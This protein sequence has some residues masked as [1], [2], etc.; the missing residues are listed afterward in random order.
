[1]PLATSLP[2]RNGFS[3]GVANY[4]VAPG[5][6]DSRTAVEAQNPAT[7][8]QT[9]N[10][11]LSTVTAAGSIINLADGTYQSVGSNYAIQ[12]NGKVV[13][14]GSGNPI[15]VKATNPGGAVITGSALGGAFTLGAWIT[16]SS[17]Y[18]FQGLRFSVQG[19]GAGAVLV[20]G[21]SS[22][23]EFFRCTFV[24][25]GETAFKTR[26]APGAPCTDIWV[27]SCKFAPS[28]T[29]TWQRAGAQ[30]VGEPTSTEFCAGLDTGNSGGTTGYYGTKGTHCMYVGQLSGA[31]FSGQ[32][33][34]DRM[35]IANCV[36]IGNTPGRHIECGPMA[37]STYI[38]NNTFYGNEPG[39]YSNTDDVSYKAGYAG[40]G[41]EFWKNDGTGAWQTQNNRVVNN[42]FVDLQ[43]HA[44]YGSTPANMTGNEV[45]NNLAW[46]L[47][48]GYDGATEWQGTR[49]DDYLQT[50]LGFTL[51]TEP[52]G[53]VSSANPLLVS[54]SK[55][56]TADLSLQDASPARGAAD[57]AYCPL[58]DFNGTARG[59][60]APCLGAFEFVPEG[61]PPQG[62]AR[63]A[64]IA[65]VVGGTRT[66]GGKVAGAG[67]GGL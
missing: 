9:I 34:H 14:G 63:L 30:W 35:V 19:L 56:E 54:P 44:V 67:G 39:F 61:P 37:R 50:Y 1:M 6:S 5:G 13:S 3:T 20:E 8:W 11:A 38:V 12:L 15:T 33:G 53:Q 32:G 58:D 60:S 45:F 18:R 7:P 43:G 22:W 57:P 41:V 46:S 65:R 48:N 16:G 49:L 4:Y 29:V 55:V 64:T 31:D 10:K 47:A 27:Y 59:A 40:T 23:I 36:F 25:T 51:Y 28:G 24:D 17:G 42:L 26:G 66:A 52:G 62:P 2:Q 21:G